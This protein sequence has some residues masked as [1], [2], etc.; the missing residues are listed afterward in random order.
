[1]PYA[2]PND[3]RRKASLEK[4]RKKYR[5]SK[6]G[7]QKR[8]QQ[9]S[10]RHQKL[11]NNPI[12]RKKRQA[13][14]IK[15]K[16]TRRDK[17]NALARAYGQKPGMKQHRRELRHHT[18]ETW[19]KFSHEQAIYRLINEEHR[20]DLAR[21]YKEQQRAS[22]HYFDTQQLTKGL[23]ALG[24]L[25]SVLESIRKD[26]MIARSRGQILLF[27]DKCPRCDSKHFKKVGLRRNRK[28][29]DIQRFKCID[30]SKSWSVKVN[31]NAIC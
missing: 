10:R 12:Y 6:K 25:N 19:E 7:K 16:Q 20:R 1:M 29:G 9:S 18:P 27:R 14:N 11:K 4:A 30:C 8:S 2:D 24:D 23:E 17:V 31:Q 15:Y 13:I 22:Q 5:Q 21:K 28:H 26:K 3:P